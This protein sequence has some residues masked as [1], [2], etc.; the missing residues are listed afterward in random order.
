MRGEGSHCA[1]GRAGSV[2]GSLLCCAR[3][4]SGNK[5]YGIALSAAVINALKPSFISR[6]PAMENAVI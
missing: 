1:P 3:A 4:H 2:W 5:P 6:E